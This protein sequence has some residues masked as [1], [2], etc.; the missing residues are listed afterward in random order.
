MIK[1]FNSGQRKHV[2]DIITGDETWIYYYDLETRSQ[3]KVWKHQ[4]L[5]DEVNCVYQEALGNEWWLFSS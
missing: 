3:C 4:T 5:H 2:C 1:K